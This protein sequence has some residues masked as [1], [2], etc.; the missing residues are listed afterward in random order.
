[1]GCFVFPQN[2]LCS[3]VGSIITSAHGEVETKAT[4]TWGVGTWTQTYLY[5]NHS[6]T[7]EFHL[8]PEKTTTKHLE[9]KFKHGQVKS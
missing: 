1:M 4:H 8:W 3:E 6:I 2:P 7:T 9:N 5:Q